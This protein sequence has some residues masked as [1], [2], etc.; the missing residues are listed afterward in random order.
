MERST[1]NLYPTLNE[2]DPDDP[3]DFKLLGQRTTTE[4]S[5]EREHEL[6]VK[7]LHSNSRDVAR[8]GARTSNVNP[9][10][11]SVTRMAQEVSLE[12]NLVLG[13]RLS[14]MKANIDPRSFVG[15]ETRMQTERLRSN[16]RMRM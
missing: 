5:L 10:S 4:A 9:R 1:T 3:T 14:S 11:F 7:R 8:L 13:R 6:R 12:L 15:L 2:L 16:A